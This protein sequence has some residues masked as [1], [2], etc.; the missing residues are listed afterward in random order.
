MR[1]EQ[2]VP[3]RA[4]E[5][6]FLG[7]EVELLAGLR[8]GNPVAQRAFF[9]RY[10]G[11]V[12]RTVRGVL[13]P[14]AELDDV[15]QDVFVAVF[16]QVGRLRAAEAV[17]EWLRLVAL[18]VAR[19]RIR[20][21]RRARWLS[22]F[23]PEELPEPTPTPPGGDAALGL[24]AVYAVLDELPADLRL[25]FALRYFEDMTVPE[26]CRALAISESTGKR[27]LRRAQAL[28]DAA[29]ARRPALAEWLE[30]RG[31]P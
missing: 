17:T 20:S 5:V 31:E 14:D 4:V 29:V 8:A 19:N 22:F 7:G 26:L 25:P 21:R 11:F 16:R 27:R 9:R 3:Q 24:R 30:L 23:A 1:A 18:G 2:P 15:V 10:A 6:V 13:G 12:E 28:F